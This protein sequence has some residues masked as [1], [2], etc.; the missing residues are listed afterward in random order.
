MVYYHSKYGR[1]GK[2]SKLRRFFIYIISI[3]LIGLIVLGGLLYQII[4]STNVWINESNASVYIPT[5]SAFDNVKSVLYING[6]IVHRSNFE[7]LAKRKNY[8]DN[9]KPGHYI[10][11]EGMSNND[12]LNL[13][14]SGNQAPVKL[15]F[16]NIRTKEDLAKKVAL[17]IEADSASIVD[18]LSDTTYQ[19]KLKL[20]QYTITTIFIPN[21]Y[22][23]FW[24]IT[25]KDFVT[26]MHWEYNNF[27]N[28]DRKSKVDSLG[29]SISEVIT[30]ASIV[31]KETSKNTEKKR[32]AGVYINRL[33]R[34]WKLQADPTLVYALGDFSIK[35]VL[36]EHKEIDSPFNTYK[37][38]GIP[39][40]PICIPSIASIDA[41]LNYEKHKYL[42]F[43]AKEDL[44]GYHNFAKNYRQHEAN[45]KK[46]RKALNKMKIWK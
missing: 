9:I 14:R 7:W 12:V 19:R 15:I 20:N 44:S 32:M 5:G 37:Y 23:I 3:I 29:I 26:R 16:N 6:V 35:R 22:N 41:V 13:L 25:A 28:E 8:P 18:L 38:R 34:K 46:Y 2:K 36:N 31:E 4:Y 33:T 40:G 24:N 39:P 10:L 17:Q 11:K 45:A 30:L 21:T 42:Y 1:K 43:C 27:W